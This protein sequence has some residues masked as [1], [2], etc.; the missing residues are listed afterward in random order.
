V[1]E[2][3]AGACKSGASGWT[4]QPVV[5]RDTYATS[6]TFGM[7]PFTGSAGYPFDDVAHR[8]TYVSGTNPLYFR[9]GLRNL[10]A[11]ST[12]RF[13]LYRPDGTVALDNSGAFANP[14]LVRNAWFW[15]SRNQTFVVTGTWT[16][17]IYVNSQMIVT[18]PLSVVPASTPIV[19]HPPLAIS[20][21]ALDPPSPSPSDVPMCLVRTSSLYHR[22]PDYDVVRYRYRW[23]VNGAV[24][25]DVISAGLA[26]AIPSG[27]IRA[28]DE[29]RCEV[30]PRDQEL[31]GTAMSIT[32][33]NPSQQIVAGGSIQSDSGRYRLLYQTDGNLVLSDERTHVAV[34]ATNTQGTPGRLVMQDDGDLV[35]YDGGNRAAWSSATA[36]NPSAYFAL[37]NDGNLVI[38][39]AVGQRIWDRLTVSAAR[40]RR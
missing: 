3:S 21:V 9:F 16:F 26:D 8:G 34:W 17:E 38:Y 19:N 37:E 32:A 5:K 20:A 7:Q 25:R 14:D 1:Y 28:G 10:P 30:T 35:L 18:A 12:Y 11:A 31:E 36:G 40:S 13:V 15:F 4:R 23:F 27:T 22:D 39:N 6:F 2:P 33:G 29:L 24:V